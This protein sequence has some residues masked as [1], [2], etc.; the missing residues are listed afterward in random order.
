M[1]RQPIR[2]G[3]L[4]SGICQLEWVLHQA[5]GRGKFVNLDRW[6][7]LP[8]EVTVADAR[9][10]VDQLV[11]RHEVLRTTFHADAEGR[12]AQTVWPPRPATVAVP[13]PGGDPA[14]FATELIEALFDVGREQPIRCGVV[15]GPPGAG[16]LLLVV[17]HLAADNAT[18]EILAEDL[19]ALL[20]GAARRT[21]TLPPP[22]PQ[23]LDLA[24]RE[25][26]ERGR[27]ASGRAIAHWERAMTE[28]PA[29]LLPGGVRDPAAG[30]VHAQL[31]S[32]AADLALAQLAPRLGVSPPAVTVAALYGV[33]AARCGLDVVATH[34][35][36]AAR[37]GRQTRRMAGAVF[38]DI[39]L[40]LDL[41][42]RPTFAEVARRAERAILLAAHHASYDVLEY[43][44]REGRVGFA[45]GN[46]VRT[47]RYLNC[48]LPSVP[49]GKPADGPLTTAELLALRPD[50]ALESWHSPDSRY[51]ND[52]YTCVAPHEGR[53]MILAAADGSLLDQSATTALVRAVEAL[54]AHAAGEGDLDFGRMTEL[55]GGRWTPPSASW[56]RIAHSWVDL[57]RI[58]ELLRAHPAVLAASVRASGPG[59]LARLTARVATRDTGLTA[60]ALR[61]FLLA[62]LANEYGAMCPH[63]FVVHL[64]DAAGTDPPATDTGDGW[65]GWPV[66][67]AGS[68]VGGPPVAPAGERESALHA[69]VRRA[70]D[71]PA[72][73]MADSYLAAG[74]RLYLLPRV[75]AALADAGYTGL[76]PADFHTVEPLTALAARLVADRPAAR[77]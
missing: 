58:E 11:A 44:E 64:A 1:T 33:L 22:G 7:T 74:G 60:T 19:A 18:M 13:E 3:P 75:C 21:N 71:L 48:W 4:Q 67:T 76:G 5:T 30:T 36:W 31:N 47:K 12:P 46:P 29:G 52:L 51:A 62:R 65:S 25:T 9:W 53:L 32:R 35:T 70:N 17:C 66:L 43:H 63:H 68:G 57:D 16:R 69:A 20:A 23:P 26:S 24:L 50:S 40:C 2:T 34:F 45:R 41:T 55:A 73:S 77:G 61:T 15:P 39:L 14:A 72:V 10:A 37:A 38:R 27:L 28:A 8:D 42:D 49:V 54:L 6:L 56:R 59:D